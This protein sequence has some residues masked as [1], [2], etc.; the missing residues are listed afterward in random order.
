MSGTAFAAV[1]L[2]LSGVMEAQEEAIRSN[3]PALADA[4]PNPQQMPGFTQRIATIISNTLEPW[5]YYGSTVEFATRREGE[6]WVIEAD[7][8]KGKPVRITD[9]D[10]DFVDSNGASA[11]WSAA[12]AEPAFGMQISDIFHHGTYESAKRQYLTELNYRGFLDAEIV[13]K[14][15]RLDPIAN[16]AR[17]TLEYHLGPQYVFGEVTFSDSPFEREFLMRY[18]NFEKGEPFS[19]RKLLQMNQRMLSEVYFE[20]VDIAPNRQTGELVVP[21]TVTAVPKRRDRYR[22][23][24]L[25]GTDSG[26]GV[27]IGA[28]RRWFNQ[29]GHYGELT[30]Q[31]TAREQNLL[32]RYRIPNGRNP[33][34]Y[35]EAQ[36]RIETE[37]TD[38]FNRLEQ[39]VSASRFRPWQGWRRTEAVTLLHEDFEIGTQDD[40]SV[41]LMPSIALSRSRGQERPIPNEGYLLRF[42]A[43]GGAESLLSETDF[44]QLDMTY[45]WI[46]SFADKYRVLSRTTLG[47]T[48]VDDFFALPPSVRYFA[49]GDRS[50]RG[51]DYQTLGPVDDAGNVVGG[52]YLLTGSIE[53]ERQITGPWRAAVF[54]DAGNAFSDDQTEEAVGAGFGVRYDTPIGLVRLDLAFPLTDQESGVQF[55][56][57]VG[58]DL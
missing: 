7:V 51:F 28:L 42:G 47:A 12:R 2:E 35:V 19:G 33:D 44:V 14:S 48:W 16:T 27:E 46:Y 49:G 17:I 6:T 41:L 10:I 9:I 3:L 34:S 15:V 11:P 45:K 39:S 5:G 24:L 57:I 56:L 32:G 43:R 38:V 30:T 31:I 18:V 4:S 37:D 1:N 25:Y 40:T 55:H 53:L 26:I 21:V 29:F 36:A 50:V 20:R 58:P 23:G 52:E 54:L 8:R 22:F 13:T